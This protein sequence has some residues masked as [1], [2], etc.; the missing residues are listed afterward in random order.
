VYTVIEEFYK[1]I[2]YSLSEEKNQWFCKGNTIFILLN[3]F[4]GGQIIINFT[5]NNHP[6]N[7]LLERNNSG[8]E[9]PFSIG[10]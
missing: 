1:S 7:L 9:L 10:R 8:E 2:F 4:T 3:A 6:L 5:K